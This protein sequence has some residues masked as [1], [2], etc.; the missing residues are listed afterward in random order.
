M[1][2]RN[3]GTPSFHRDVS[4]PH[5]NHLIQIGCQLLKRQLTFAVGRKPSSDDKWSR[6]RKKQWG[7][8]TSKQAI[9]A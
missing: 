6:Q 3:T 2:E 7:R 9:V 5:I 8:G 4:H 1:L